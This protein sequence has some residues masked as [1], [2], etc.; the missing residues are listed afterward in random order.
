MIALHKL[1]RNAD[2]F[3]L[4]PDLIITVEATPDTVVTLATGSKLLVSETPDQVAA[5]VCAWRARVAVGAY[6]L[7]D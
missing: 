1:G 5:A 7:Y 2:E 3:Q 4:N 6:Q